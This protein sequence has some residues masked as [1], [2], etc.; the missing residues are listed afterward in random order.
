MQ[1][2]PLYESHLRLGAKMVDFGGWEMPVNTPAASS[3]STTRPQAVGVFDV[4]HM[5]EMHFRGD[6]AA[7]ACSALVTNDVGALPTVARCTRW[8]ATERGIVDD[9]IVYRLAATHYLIVSTRQPGQDRAY[10]VEHAR[11]Q[12]R[13]DRRSDET[14]A[15]SRSRV[16]PRRAGAALTERALAALPRFALH[17]GRA[18]RR[19]AVRSRAPATPARTVSSSSAPPDA[20]RAVGGAARGRGRRRRQAGRARRARHAA[21]GGAAAALRQRHRR[22]HHPARG[23]AR[24]GGQARQGRIHRPRGAAAIQTRAGVQRKLVGFE[25]RGRGIARHGYP[26]LRRRTAP[27]SGPST[28]G[29]PRARRV[30]KNIGLGYVPAGARPRRERAS[31]STAAASR[32]D[33]EVVK[34]PFYKRAEG[35]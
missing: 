10:F 29:R 28:S 11:P 4:C 32:V 22:D 27:A 30:G 34:G 12:C 20:R 7:E 5:G 18:R 19:P 14:G 17:T 24:L 15:A 33:A 21:A 35:A 23:R 16:R 25:M 6:G 26:H 8:R 3:T 9:L 13:F 31:R 1:R 2:T